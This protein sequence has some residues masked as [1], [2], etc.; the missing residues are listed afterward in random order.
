MAVIKVEETKETY[1]LSDKRPE[2]E[3]GML[4]KPNYPCLYMDEIPTGLFN[5][6][7][8]GATKEFI[9]IAKV[10]SISEREQDTDKEKSYKC[11]LEIHSISAPKE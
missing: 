10:K 3:T 8:V 2:V 5:K 1:N 6:L 9:I 4:D 7:V 11:E